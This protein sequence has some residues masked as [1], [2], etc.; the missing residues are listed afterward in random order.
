MGAGRRLL[1]FGLGAL[2]LRAT[3]LGASAFTLNRPSVSVA[4]GHLCVRS[5]LHQEIPE[6]F[7]DAIHRGKPTLL[8]IEFRV[9][10]RRAL[11]LPDKTVAQAKIAFEIRYDTLGR[12]Y[13]V[14]PSTN[15]VPGR[16]FPLYSREQVRELFRNVEHPALLPTTDLHP[17]EEYRVRVR[18]SFSS[19]YLVFP[20]SLLIDVEGLYNMT[21]KWTESESFR[22]REFQ[23]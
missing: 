5:F 21:T 18:E 14:V 12:V 22:G 20:L 2:L 1:V 23:P 6:D 16:R 8:S 10:R 19:V 11:L 9:V 17:D 7:F 13:R 4:D 3:L 15:D